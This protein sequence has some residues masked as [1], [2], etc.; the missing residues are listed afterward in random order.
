MV[1]RRKVA[2]SYRSDRRTVSTKAGLLDFLS[3][4]TA[5]A[6]PEAEGLVDEL[7]EIASRTNGG[8]KAS[9]DTRETIDELVRPELPLASASH[10][11]AL[12]F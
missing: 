4:G 10:Y 1:T 8:S 11:Y 5:K 3:P 6:S 9:S 7:L 2:Q 12:Q